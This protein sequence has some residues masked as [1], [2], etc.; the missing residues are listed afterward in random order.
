MLGRQGVVSG[1]DLPIWVRSAGVRAS[2]VPMPR[3]A[4]KEREA[5]PFQGKGGRESDVR[6]L[7]WRK[8]LSRQR[9]NRLSKDRNPRPAIVVGGSVDLDGAHGVGAGER[10]QSMSLGRPEAGPEGRQ[11]VSP[12]GQAHPAFDPGSGVA[13]SCAQQR[14]GGS[15]WAEHRAVC[16]AG[17]AVSAGTAQRSAGQL[18]AAA[19]EACGDPEGRQQD[20]N[21][22]ARNS[23]ATGIIHLM[24]FVF[25]MTAEDVP[26]ARPILEGACLTRCRPLSNMVYC[27]CVAP[28]RCA[29]IDPV[30]NDAMADAV[31]LADLADAESVVWGLRSWNLVFVT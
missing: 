5:K 15:G 18:S 31:S 19:G 8:A 25:G 12:G 3:A 20:R 9:R 28:R 22:T 1:R 26:T 17:D 23:D 29:T 27:A 13:E 7:E 14:G 6:G 30:V 21:T 2:I 4:A 10:R 16:T 24:Q 11:M